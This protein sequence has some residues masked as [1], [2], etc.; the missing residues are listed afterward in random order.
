[1]SSL[2]LVPVPAA[3]RLWPYCADSDFIEDK[4]DSEARNAKY[5]M[6]IAI[7]AIAVYFVIRLVDDIVDLCSYARCGP[8]TLL[9][10]REP[11]MS[12]RFCWTKNRI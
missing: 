9:R 1:M 12:I 11:M 2:C 3:V 4:S 8:L 7:A 5:N 10:Q 6:H